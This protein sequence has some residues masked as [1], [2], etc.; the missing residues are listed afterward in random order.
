MCYSK[1]DPLLTPYTLI[2]TEWL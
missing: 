1:L 2:I